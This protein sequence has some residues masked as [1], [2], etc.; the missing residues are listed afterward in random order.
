[1]AGHAG[2]AEIDDRHV[3][4]VALDDLQAGLGRRRFSDD[5]NLLLLQQLTQPG[6]EKHVVVDDDHCDRRRH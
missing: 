2:K 1:M 5:L 6:A 3:G 4:R